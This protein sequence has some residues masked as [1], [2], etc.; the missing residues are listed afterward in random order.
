MSC[1]DKGACHNCVMLCH[2]MSCY[3]VLCYVMLCH[4]MSCY[5]MLCH[6]MACYVMLCHVM[7]CYAMLCH[8]HHVM[9]GSCHVIIRN[10][11][12]CIGKDSISEPRP[13][14]NCEYARAYVYNQK[15]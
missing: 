9:S 6:A 5:V 1:Y 10:P 12:A 15:P 4:V 11:R 7:A 3:A 13:G 2:D 14:H 8:V